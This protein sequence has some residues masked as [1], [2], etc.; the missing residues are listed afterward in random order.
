M[1][2]D[3]DVSDR[4]AYLQSHYGLNNREFAERVEIQPSAVAHL[5]NRRNAPSYAVICSILEA[6]P[7]VRAEWFLLG[8][9][10]PFVKK[11]TGATSL[12]PLD[13]ALPEKGEESS[14]EVGAAVDETSEEQHPPQGVEA[15]SSMPSA[16]SDTSPAC[17]EVE[18]PLGAKPRLALLYQDGTYRLFEPREGE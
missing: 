11:A 6:F 1:V 18:K 13:I 15:H 2:T 10:E 8:R 17:P 7:E 16:S 4:I 5:L 3:M 14:A 9:G 12:L